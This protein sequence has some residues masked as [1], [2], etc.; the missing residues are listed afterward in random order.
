MMVSLPMKHMMF[1]SIFGTTSMNIFFLSDEPVIAATMMCDKHIPKMI[2]EAAQMLSTAHRMLD[3]Q[4]EKRESK[5]G[6]RMVKYYAHPDPHM[7]EVL[8]KAVHH[9]HPSTVWTRESLSNYRWHYVHYRA[10]LSEF[11]T[12][13]GKRHKSADLMDVLEKIPANVPDIGRTE[14]ALAMKQYPQCVVEG[15][16]VQSYRNFYVASKVDFAKWEKG[17]EAPTWWKEAVGE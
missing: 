13:F 6:K 5:S 8:Y 11:H 9:N 2:V 3:G 12:R 16:P 15:N 17:R 10:L 4:L 14:F 7:E 1:A